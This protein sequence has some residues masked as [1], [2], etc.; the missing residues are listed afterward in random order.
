MP[1]AARGHGGCRQ[2]FHKAMRMRS[3]CTSIQGHRRECKSGVRKAN[4]KCL[5][6]LTAEQKNTARVQAKMRRHAKRSIREGAATKIQS[7][8]RGDNT[9]R[10]MFLARVAAKA[11]PKAFV[12]RRGRSASRI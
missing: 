8:L 2:G 7:L 10:K 11:K 12:P 5:R 9:R 4:G 6:S 1:R 3:V